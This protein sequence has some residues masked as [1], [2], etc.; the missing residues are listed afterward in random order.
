MGQ[1]EHQPKRPEW[2]CEDCGLNWPCQPARDR[3]RSE[4][5]GGLAL[6]MLMWSYFED[7]FGDIKT[8][9]DGAFDRFIG[10]TRPGGSS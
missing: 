8:R 3:L 10:W 9:S 4:T 7:F 5:G 2:T 1:A 6:G